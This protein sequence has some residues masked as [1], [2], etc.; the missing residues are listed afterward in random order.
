MISS[1]LRDIES[2]TLRNIKEREK[3][4]AEAKV[5]DDPDE[6]SL[7]ES[8]EKMELPAKLEDDSD[9]E[10]REKQE[11]PFEVVAPVVGEHHKPDERCLDAVVIFEHQIEEQSSGDDDEMH[12]P[13]PDGSEQKSGDGNF[14]PDDPPQDL[15][16]LLDQAGS[17][18][19]SPEQQQPSSNQSPAPTHPPDVA[20][21]LDLDVA[22][23]TES[24]TTRETPDV[25]HQ[26]EQHS[27]GQNSVDLL[28]EG[29]YN[30]LEPL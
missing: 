24:T 28:N 23:H 29:T 19:D 18:P 8:V 25:M 26:P 16:D 22:R 10:D 6:K 30:T 20:D 21:L 1:L 9:H 4:D 14:T 17:F 2:A 13:S 7:S 12:S 15:P 5:K 11:D 27:E 3:E